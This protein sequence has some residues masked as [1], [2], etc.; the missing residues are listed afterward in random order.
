MITASHNPANDNGIKIVDPLGEML[1]AKWEEY[2]GAM[3]RVPD[4]GLLATL[5]SIVSATKTDIASPAHLALAWDTRYG[6][7]S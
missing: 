5:Q 1:E 4:S 6:I 2:A 3:V 7:L